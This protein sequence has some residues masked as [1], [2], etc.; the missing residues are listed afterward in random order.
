MPIQTR[1]RRSVAAALRT[2]HGLSYGHEAAA[3]TEAA[4]AA[5]VAL[6]QI[7]FQMR[8]SGGIELWDTAE[9]FVTLSIVGL[10]D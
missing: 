8:S 9:N 10:S 4:V 2:C 3:I 5:Y 1:S 6:P 7:S